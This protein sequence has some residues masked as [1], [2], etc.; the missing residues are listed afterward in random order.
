MIWKVYVRVLLDLVMSKKVQSLSRLNPCTHA[1]HNMF[2]FKRKIF[3][4]ADK[5]RSNTVRKKHEFFCTIFEQ[6]IN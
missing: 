3:E 1:V 4:Y 2:L 5:K 6:Q